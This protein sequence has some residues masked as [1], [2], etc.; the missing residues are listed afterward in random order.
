MSDGVRLDA[1]GIRAAAVNAVFTIFLL[2]YCSQ[3]DMGQ[4]WVSSLIILSALLNMSIV[5]ATLMLLSRNKR[6]DQN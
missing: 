3:R 2:I 1:K 6:A 5:I 4:R